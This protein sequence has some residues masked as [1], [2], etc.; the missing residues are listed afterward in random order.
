MKNKKEINEEVKEETFDEFC[1]R[2]NITWTL[3]Y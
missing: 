1:K 2:Y 3:D